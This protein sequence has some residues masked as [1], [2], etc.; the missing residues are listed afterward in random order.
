MPY[1]D[2]D[3]TDTRARPAEIRRSAE[4]LESISGDLLGHGDNVGSVLSQMALSFSEVIASAIAAQI[5]DNMAALEAAVEVTQYGY[6]VGA[7]WAA[8][9]EAFKAARDELIARWELAEIE[10]F[11]VPTPLNLWPPPE[12]AEAERLRLEN[13]V[14]VDDARSVALNSFILEGHALWESFQDKVA[15]KAR[16]FG[17]GPTAENLAL[18]ASYLGWGAMTLWPESAPAPVSAAEGV[19]AGTTVVGG[20]DGVM[21]PQAVADALADVAAII[22]RAESGQELT[23]AEIDF[24]AAFY[25]T[26]GERVTELPD[27]LARTSFTVTTSAPSSR[28]DDDSPPTY[29]AHTVDGLD[30]ALVGALTAASANGLLVLS[31]NGPGGGG[32]SRLP[33]WV[34]NSVD[35]EIVPSTLPTPQTAGA[36]ESLMELGELMEFSTVEAGDGLSREM[37]DALNRMFAAVDGLESLGAEGTPTWGEQVDA[38]GQSFLD[39]IARNDGACFDI[40]TGSQMPDGYDAARFFG[41]MYSFDWSDDGAAAAS[42][43]DFIPVW[44]VSDDPVEQG[45]AQ[46]AMLDLVQ[47]VTGDEGFELLMDG[48]GTSGVAAESAVGQVNPA[49]TQGFVAAIAPFMDQFAAEQVNNLDPNAVPKSLRD[50]PFDTRVRFMTLIGTDPASA[51]ALAGL[52]YAYEQQELYEYAVSGSTEVNGGNVGRIRGIVDAGL[53]NAE[54]D[55]GADQ[56]E[57]EAAA[58]R[59]RQVGADIAQGLLGAIPVPGV[60]GLVDTVFAIFNAESIE[61][62]STESATPS[63]GRTEAE[64]RY[65]TAAGVMTALVATGQLPPSAMPTPFVGPASAQDQPSTED[66]TQALVDAAAAAGYDLN[67]I[68]SRIESAYSDP[69]LVDERE[70]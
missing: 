21:G 67:L 6:G 58:A 37:A 19:T 54:V 69:D 31:R 39:V 63:P 42:L 49:V 52:A 33:T 34:R 38:T 3:P 23:P 53:F 11:G 10:N 12:P 44:A 59:S 2:F 36:F 20:L 29:S 5:G 45:R 48:V 1:T 35:D 15:E 18:V 30:P 51:T 26:V 66:F 61:Q 32:Y 41:N 60:A 55:A 40:V 7:S 24:L 17:E 13:R 56:E 62:G 70:D 50:L 47:I 68:L 22:R 46:A 9:V 25:E 64:R 14:A 8:D 65:D 16:M 57:A 28:T 27:Y 4:G 43:T